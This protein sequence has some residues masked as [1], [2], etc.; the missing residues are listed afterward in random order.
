[1]VPTRCVG[2]VIGTRCVPNRRRGSNC[3]PTQ[4]VGTSKGGIDLK[5]LP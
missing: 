1:M 4:S 5:N 3:I 2:T